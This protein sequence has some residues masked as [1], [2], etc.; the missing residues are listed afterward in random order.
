MTSMKFLNVILFII[1]FC[2]QTSCVLNTKRSNEINDF[3]RNVEY[4][5][6]N[7]KYKFD[8]IDSAIVIKHYGGN[9]VKYHE[10]CVKRGLH[11]AE[12]YKWDRV[13]RHLVV[14][15]DTA[16]KYSMDIGFEKPFYFMQYLK[17]DTMQSVQKTKILEQLKDKLAALGIENA[18]SLNAKHLLKAGF[19]KSFDGQEGCGDNCKCFNVQKQ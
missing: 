1:L 11:F 16:R 4:S 2:G 13:A 12:N 7:Y 15:S 19:R 6:V 10:Y 8:N 9:F 3:K 5:I 17:C 18:N 14:C